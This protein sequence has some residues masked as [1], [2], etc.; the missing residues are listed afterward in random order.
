MRIVVMGPSGAGKSTV[1][2]ALADLIGAPFVDGD[3]L[4][5]A[6]NVAKMAAGRPLDDA[7]R[8]PWLARVGDALHAHD[9]IVVA[10]SALKRGYRDAI[11][12]REPDAVF[13]ELVVDR[14]EL[15]TR[16]STRGAHFMPTTLLDSQLRTLEPLDADERGARVTA[17]ADVA[18][19]AEMVAERLEL[20][21]CGSPSGRA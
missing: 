6:E 9:D 11:R 4:H 14:D 18:R 1:G 17:G 5:H 7:D 16:M 19:T 2:R 8:M 13:V 20:S 3:D 15:A 21:P 10:C 12:R